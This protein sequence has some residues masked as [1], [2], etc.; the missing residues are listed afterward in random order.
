[1]RKNRITYGEPIY[2]TLS[3]LMD[4]LH[5][6]SLSGTPGDTLV[7]LDGCDCCS[8]IDEGGVS[9]R[10]SLAKNHSEKVIYIRRKAGFEDE[11]ES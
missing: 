3:N 5:K 8:N 6:L 4:V 7:L 1:M 11:E 9:V 2:W 10:D